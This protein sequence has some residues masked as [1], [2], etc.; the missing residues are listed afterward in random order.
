MRL[1]DMSIENKNDNMKGRNSRK[2]GLIFAFLLLTFALISSC[3]Y[4]RRSGRGGSTRRAAVARRSST[5]TR[6][7]ARARRASVR[8]LA[9]RGL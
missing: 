1:R 2:Q 9:H 7:A 3:D 8:R 6:R 5:S 4:N